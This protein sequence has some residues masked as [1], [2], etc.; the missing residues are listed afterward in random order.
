MQQEINHTREEIK[1]LRRRIEI[2][3]LQNEH[4]NDNKSL[5]PND[6][7]EIHTNIDDFVNKLTIQKCHT[8]LTIKTNDFSVETECLLDNG[9]DVNVLHEGLIPTKYFKKTNYTIG[10]ATHKD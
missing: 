1:N 8:I 2:L 10:L 9:A 5:D 4:Q 7:D 3:E 6:D